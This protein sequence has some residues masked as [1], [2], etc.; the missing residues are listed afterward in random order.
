MNNNLNKPKFNFEE[1]PVAYFSDNVK[2]NALRNE[3]IKNQVR[4]SECEQGNLENTFF[5]DEN[6]DLINK[7]LVIS[8]F[9]RTK[10]QIRIADQSKQ[11]LVIVMRYVFLE[12]A[13]HL[14]YDIKGQIRELNCRVV[15]EIL[16]NIITNVNQRIDYLNEINNPRQ[17]LPN[18]INVNKG[19]RLNG[20]VSSNL[21]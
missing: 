21:F 6:M 2:S 5:S 10:G 7:Q 14:P 1:L 18:P 17:I 13:R 8:I 16:P 15:G 19:R 11:Q 4:I 12:H 3:L 20:G 9:N